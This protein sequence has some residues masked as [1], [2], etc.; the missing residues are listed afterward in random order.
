M[1]RTARLFSFAF[2]ALLF[3]PMAMAVLGQAARIVA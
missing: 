1:T 3:A 2:A